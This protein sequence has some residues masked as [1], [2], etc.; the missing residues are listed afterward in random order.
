MAT[1]L[2]LN[3]RLINLARKLG[4]HKT[5]KDAVNAALE[6]YVNRLKQLEILDLVGKIAYDPDYDYKAG[7]RKART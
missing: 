6:G 5:K 7:R 2:G 1:N 3:D 4:R